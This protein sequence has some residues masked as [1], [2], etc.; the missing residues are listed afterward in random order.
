MDLDAWRPRRQAAAEGQQRRQAMERMYY[1]SQDL[2]QELRPS[3][4]W[5]MRLSNLKVLGCDDIYSD[6]EDEDIG[7]SREPDPPGM[8]K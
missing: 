4:Y 8:E 5:D 6:E 7:D 1:P 3:H 2:L